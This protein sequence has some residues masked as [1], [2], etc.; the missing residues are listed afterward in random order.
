MI[1]KQELLNA[2]LERFNDTE[3]QTYGLF[4]VIYNLIKD[5]PENPKGEWIEHDNAYECSNCQIIRAKGRT[6]KYNFCPSCG[7]DMRRDN[8]V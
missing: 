2:L 7:A 6:G 5:F 4:L 3:Y 8:N 1:N